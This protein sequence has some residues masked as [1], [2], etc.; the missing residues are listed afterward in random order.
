ME[1]RFII[2]IVLI[3]AILFLW[4]LVFNRRR[5]PAPT[6]LDEKAEQQTQKGESE[7]VQDESEPI[8]KEL[9]ELESYQKVPEETLVQVDTKLYQVQL[10]TSGARA[11]SWKLKE[12]Y[13]RN[14]DD[15]QYPDNIDLIPENLVHPSAR[16]WL[17]VKFS[18]PELQD[19]IEDAQ[20]RPDKKSLDI[21][22]SGKE[23]DSIEFIYP[24]NQ[25]L[26]I[27]KKVTFFA[28]NY[29]ADVEIGFQNESEDSVEIDGYNL[30]WGAG[31]TK[32]EVISDSEM[33]SEGPVALVKTEKGLDLIRHWKRTGFACFGGKYVQLPEQQ[34]PISWVG[35]SSKY[36]LAVLIPGS[37]SWWSNAEVAGKRYDLI[38]ENKDTVLPPSLGPNEVW[39]EWGMNTSIAL[40]R[41]DFSIPTG[42]SVK[43]QYRVY[44]GPKKW[45]IVRNIKS[46]GESPENLQIG[47][48]IKF[49]MFSPLGKATLWI[50][51]LI[52]DLV[53]NYGV[54]II[55]ITILIK[56]IYLPLTHKSFKSMRKMQE[57]GPKLNEL[58]E[59]Y[60]DDAQRLQKETMKLYKK[61]GVNPMGG[62]LPL[63]FQMPVFWALFTTLRGAVE[64][65]GAVFISGWVTD[66]SL[67]DTVAMIGGF[68]LR[69]L[70][71]LMT[72]SMLA[73]QLLFG[74]GGQGQNNKMMAFMPLIF[75]VIFYGMPSG[76]V[77]YWLCNNIL[78]IG[79][80]YLIRRQQDTGIEDEE[81]KNVKI[82]KNNDKTK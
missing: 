81:E 62:C 52:Y 46:L 33:A 26:T 55:F 82:T 47:K 49:G 66:L 5:Q 39:N 25:G 40:I 29:F 59:K 18:D 3:F 27:S 20:W 32:D 78:S 28:D 38:A 76:L 8:Q 67:P 64:L 22:S 77:L 53:N 71:V 58:R 74:S 61:H 44:I 50:L 2:A 41:P 19:E 11:V 60:R 10:T 12:F 45:D 6:S 35:L 65:R 68:P 4:P 17:T 23:Q 31:I 57:L 73:Q 36:F 43:H 56:T 34:G 1:K 79:H 69:I 51:N 16:K 7:S 80:Q 72:G 75:A 21:I 15:N 9:K 48:I 24:S 54:A 14:G 30:Y 42:Q 13:E 70:P 63:L 37:D